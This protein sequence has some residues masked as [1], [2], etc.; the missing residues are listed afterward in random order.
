M[1]AVLCLTLPLLAGAASPGEP[2]AWT[3]REAEHLLN[4]AGFGARP[5]EIAYAVRRGREAFVQELLDGYPEDV[6][7]FFFDPP[8][9]PKEQYTDGMSEERKREIRV[10]FKRDDRDELGHFASWW[11]GQML[12]GPYP[13]RER[14]TLFWHG[15]FTSSYREVKLGGAMIRQN[16]LFRAHA[17][18]SFR[19]LLDEVI[20]D[21]AMVLYL[22]N[23][24]NRKGNPNENLARE[25]MEL[26]TLGEGHY[27]EEDVKEAAR[28][29]TGFT[30]RYDSGVTFRPGRHDN[31]RKVVL[32]VSG[33]LDGDDLLDILLDQEQCP[34]WLAGRLLRYFEGREPSAQRLDA[35]ASLLREADYE[36]RPFLEHLFSDPEFYSD[37]IVGRRIAS[38]LDYLI[39]SSR[40]LGVQPPPRLVWLAAGQL[41]ERL[42]DP[43]NVKGW[44]GGP[45]WITT[46][47]M[48]QRGNLAGMLLGVV[49][50]EDVVRPEPPVE[51]ADP[52]GEMSMTA[53]EADTDPARMK[54]KDLGADMFDMRRMLSE[55]YWP[56]IH[57]TARLQRA[58]V[59]G[60]AAI[61]DFLCD[62][63]LAVEV[64]DA[65]RAA[66]AEF[67]VAER[68]DLG[69]DDDELLG[70][71]P[72]AEHVLRRLAHVIL[73]L[74]E[75]QLL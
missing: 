17:L 31:G 56:G 35:Y 32:G 3:A 18:G 73:S 36:V 66:L 72:E 45:A 15:Y 37:E 21:P 11:I 49:R 67:L 28:A 41:G 61:V 29:L 62:E 24:K 10:Q 13:L 50:L 19:E 59:R 7:S 48:L 69:L 71:G 26:F 47:S 74:P 40:R 27:T 9:P 38:P 51:D 65:G 58:D 63:L 4:R 43:P 54:K 44:E 53:A 16:E 34:R 68:A 23:D 5:A 22:D 64:S 55:F 8:T 12:D 14:M 33:R 75:A 70:A 46:S 52:D 39:G 57:L 30:A 42:F 20:R 2:G 25:L 1:I 6:E 60:D